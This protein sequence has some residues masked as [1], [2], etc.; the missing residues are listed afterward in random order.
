MKK[1]GLFLLL[2][3]ADFATKVFAVHSIPP[4][5]SSSYP[6]G[7]IGIFSFS[8]ISLSFNYIVNSGAAWGIFAG[9]AK[10]LFWIRSI[11][12][13]ILVL[14]SPKR[15][16][17]MLIL[18]GAVGNIID[19]CIYGHVIDFIHFNFWGYTFPIFNLADSCITIG[20]LSLLLFPKQKQFQAL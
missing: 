15:F 8:G 20:I 6:F 10:L 1:L 18:T 11:I 9:H 5:S 7:G 17:I 14:F 13:S 12:V 4:F 2:L 19:Y 3:L 16:P